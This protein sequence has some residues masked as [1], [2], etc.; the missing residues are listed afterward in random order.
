M[1]PVTFD[2]VISPA[3]ADFVG[4]GLNAESLVRLGFL[5]VIARQDIVGSIVRFPQSA[6]NAFCKD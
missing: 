3:D 4:S 5:V 2:E 6:T 1:E